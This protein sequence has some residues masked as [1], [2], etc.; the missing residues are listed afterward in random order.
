MNEQDTFQPS[1]SLKED[2]TRLILQSVSA[3]FT[4]PLQASV[5]ESKLQFQF[6]PEQ[7]ESTPH[8]YEFTWSALHISQNAFICCF[9]LESKKEISAIDIA[10][11]DE[12]QEV[13]AP[14]FESPPK[15]E[16]CEEQIDSLPLDT[17]GPIRLTGT[18]AQEREHVRRARLRA[19]K[20]LL[21]S[22]QLLAA[23]ME[24]YGV[25]ES[26]FESDS[27]SDS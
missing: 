20:A 21:R 14:T 13:T 16:M 17:Q 12:T 6:L 26:E 10:F 5:V 18:R 2:C 27:E 4:K 23:Y 7:S 3:F 11:V 1:S 9:T 19:A 15:D 22:E 24:K 25:D 8:S